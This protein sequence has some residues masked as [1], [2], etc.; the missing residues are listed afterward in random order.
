MMTSAPASSGNTENMEVDVCQSTTDTSDESEPLYKLIRRLVREDNNER[1]VL[2]N[3]SLKD[4]LRKD[5]E[6]DLTHKSDLEVD[7][8]I[9]V[10]KKFLKDWPNWNEF[11]KTIQEN[12]D[13]P[14]NCQTDIFYKEYQGLKKYLQQVLMFADTQMKPILTKLEKQKLKMTNEKTKSKK[15]A[16][17]QFVMEV[18]CSRQQLNTLFYRKPHPKQFTI[19]H[20]PEN[21]NSSKISLEKLSF[22]DLLNWPYLAVSV[23]L[24]NF[25]FI[26]KNSSNFSWK[27]VNKKLPDFDETLPALSSE[28]YW[29]G[30]GRKKV[31]FRKL[32]LVSYLIQVINYIDKLD[33]VGRSDG[34]KQHLMDLFKEIKSDILM[35]QAHVDV[36]GEYQFFLSKYPYVRYLYKELSEE[37]LAS[38]K[39]CQDKNEIDK[40]FE[41]KPD[42]YDLQLQEVISPA[43]TYQM[44]KF[45]VFFSEDQRGRIFSINYP[46]FTDTTSSWLKLECTCCDIKF[47]G[48]LSIYEME[49]HFTEHHNFEPDWQCP[50]CKATFPAT[51]LSRN[52]WFHSC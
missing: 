8:Y 36:N 21:P 26:R 13:S 7:I 41:L 9:N 17:E 5:F 11:E 37:E 44:S 16:N 48:F 40:V 2:S 33:M 25:E 39:P 3:S 14:Q 24:P 50:E 10:F 27:L 43:I 35:A 1:T 47:N 29:K 46:C 4:I 22:R 49:Q 28:L 18:T 6:M 45:A 19:F 20:I 38:S 34:K 23:T 51:Y 42:K 52:R 15:N 32:L 12:K 30:N 31:I